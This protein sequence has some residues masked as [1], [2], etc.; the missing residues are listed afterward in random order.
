VLSEFVLFCLLSAPFI[1]LF[2]SFHIQ[3]MFSNDAMRLNIAKSPAFVPVPHDFRENVHTKFVR[4]LRA[5]VCFLCLFYIQFIIV[6][7]F[8]VVFIH[9]LSLF[10]FRS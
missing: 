7:G 10:L 3:V 1:K 2:L 6:L 9:Y 8:L 4:S 5:D